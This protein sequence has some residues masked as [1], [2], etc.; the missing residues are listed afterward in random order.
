[1]YNVCV[2]NTFS[3]IN[4]PIT[5]SIGQPKQLI[6]GYKYQELMNGSRVNLIALDNQTKILNN[7]TLICQ[8]IGS[9]AI[10]VFIDGVMIGVFNIYTYASL[11]I[12]NE[13]NLYSIFTQELP[14]IYNDGNAYNYA[15]NFATTKM[16]ADLYKFIYEAY[17]NAFASLGES[18]SYNLGFEELYFGQRGIISGAAYP[19]QVLNLLI[20][21][22]NKTGITYKDISIFLSKIIFAANGLPSQVY[23]HQSAANSICYI[24][25]YIRSSNWQL[26]VTGNTELG[27]TTKLGAPANESLVKFLVVTLL[28]RLMPVSVKWVITY[29]PLADFNDDFNAASVLDNMYIDDN[30]NYDAYCAVNNNNVFNTKG[31]KK[32][33]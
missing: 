23:M 28:T 15:D 16:F 5:L 2:N 29:K 14:T 32:N 6:S 1:M 4:H 27:I 31:Y 13:Q 26:G 24:D 25:L 17:Y 18:S 7:T 11:D 22:S 19:A 12:I 21:I 8:T 33:V 9:H 20:Q 30:V 10:Q 3:V